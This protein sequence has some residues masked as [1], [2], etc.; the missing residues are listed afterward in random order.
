MAA[1]MCTRVRSPLPYALTHMPRDTVHTPRPQDATVDAHAE[2]S[3]GNGG[4]EVSERGYSYAYH[5]HPAPYAHLARD[6][7][8]V[9]AGTSPFV[10][11]S[12]K[13]QNVRAS[14]IDAKVS[15]RA[16]KQDDGRP[17]WQ[18][19]FAQR[20]AHE[21]NGSPRRPHERTPRT[22]RYGSQT[23]HSAQF[24]ADRG[25]WNAF[26][27]FRPSASQHRAQHRL[28]HAI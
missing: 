16:L 15:A 18:G 20:D 14:A 22:D 28:C 12:C 13:C 21:E 11:R 7:T 24:R 19:T 3:Q 4:T 5:E 2:L 17:A 1:G 23:M 26:H 10:T 9:S 25:R 8:C 27:L 6:M